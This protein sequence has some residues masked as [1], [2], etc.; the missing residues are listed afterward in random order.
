M[1][2][3]EQEIEN[4]LEK[5]SH[6]PDLFARF[7]A[8][9]A[10]DSTVFCRGSGPGGK[11]PFVRTLA[12][13]GRVIAF[14][15]T[16]DQKTQAHSVLLA[17]V[18]R[19]QWYPLDLSVTSAEGLREQFG[20][21]HL[22]ICRHPDVHEHPFWINHL[23]DWS[24]YVKENEGQLLVTTYDKLEQLDILKSLLEKK[25][26]PSRIDRYT[27]GY[28]YRPSWSLKSFQSDNFVFVVEG[29]GI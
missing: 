6:L 7:L 18:A 20:S 15:N 28:T 4:L 3:K 17:A 24:K 13:S 8:P 11:L 2:S 26:V 12:P 29:S 21:P 27:K 25:I 19:T 1:F 23:T 10:P 9:I 16:L 22:V 5:E 14:D